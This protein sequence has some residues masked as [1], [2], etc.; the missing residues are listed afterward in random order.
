M[1]TVTRWSF[2]ARTY[3]T[4]GM[5]GLLVQALKRVSGKDGEPVIQLKTAFGGGK[6]HSMLAL[7]HIM[8]GRV[9]ADR[10][11]SI[12]PV[13]AQ[14]GVSALPKANVAVLVGTALDPTRTKRPINFPRHHHQH[15]LGRNGS[16]AG[17]IGWP[18]GTVRFCQGCR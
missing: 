5:T 1:N 6:T 18:S 17:G 13:L 11:P 16:A 8:R 2:F 14:A 15:F 9:S 12:K 7:Y 3:V 10:I 4:E